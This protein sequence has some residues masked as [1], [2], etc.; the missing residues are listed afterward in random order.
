MANVPPAHGKATDKP[1]TAHSV[2]DGQVRQLKKPGLGAYVP[3]AHAVAADK[4]LTPHALPAGQ[5]VHVVAPE[6]GAKYWGV[7]DAQSDCADL[8]I[9]VLNVPALQFTNVLDA[10]GQ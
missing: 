8:P 5:I 2:P 6:L 7:H 3:G 1:L 10:S 9:A 4:P